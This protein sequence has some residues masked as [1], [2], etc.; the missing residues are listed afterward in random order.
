MR[1][2]CAAGRRLGPGL[3]T[4]FVLTIWLLGAVPVAAAADPATF[5]TPTASSKF[6]TGIDFVQPI[7]ITGSIERAEV[8]V[9]T[10]GG[11]GP[12]VRGVPEAATSGSPTLRYHLDLS[13][14]NTAPNTPFTARWRLVAADGTSSVGPPITQTYADDR[15]AWK[16]LEGT[17]VRVHWTEGDRAFGGRALKIGDDAI[18]ATSKLLGVTEDEPIDFFIYADQAA[19]YDALGPATRENVGGQARPDIRTLFALITPGEINDSWVEIVVPHELT[20]VVFQTA[21]DN[22]YHEPPHWLN[23]GVA[24]YLSAGY[25]DG[26]R[27]QVE[28]AAKDGS[29]IPL[30]G[31][32]GSFPTTRDRFFLAYAESVSAVERIV[33]VNGRDALV[34]LIRSYQD[35]VSDDEAFKAALGRDLAGFESDWLGEIGAKPPP[36]LGPRPASA[37]PLPEG[38]TG[39]QPNPSFEVTGSLA[40]QPPTA[41]R[42]GRLDDDPMARFLLPSVSILGIVVIAVVLTMARRRAARRLGAGAGGAEPAWNQLYGRPREPEEAEAPPNPFAIHFGPD[43]A[44]EEGP[45]SAPADE[46]GVDRRPDAH[47]A[48]PP[49]RPDPE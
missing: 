22:P 27:Q 29:I 26:D 16:T 46:P 4:S 18:A 41:P 23:E 7:T 35:G 33:R 5:G 40:P 12:D 6:G 10:P 3:A 2:I 14:G 21:V 19:F 49:P 28:A 45:E 47:R 8:L 25:E 24:V 38:W 17:V 37:G 43:S 36:R 44:S 13:D 30:S 39:P 15:F 42:P 1:R 48:P 31:L 34:R 9:S 20:H 32:A 11:I